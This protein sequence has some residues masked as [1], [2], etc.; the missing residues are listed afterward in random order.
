MRKT[1]RF[2][3]LIDTDLADGI[4]KTAELYGEEMGNNPEIAEEIGEANDELIKAQKSVTKA[5]DILSQI[6]N[7][8]Y[9]D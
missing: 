8:C 3:K 9:D 7:E 5:L 6:Y 1:I 4:I 2:L